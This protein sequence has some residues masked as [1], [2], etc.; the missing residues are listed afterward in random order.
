LSA[1]P[2]QVQRQADEAQRLED[3]LAAEKAARDNLN[4]DPKPTD[5]PEPEPKVEPKPTDAPAPKVE[6]PT[7]TPKPDENWEQ[8]F[9][10]LQGM[11]KA[12]L[13]REVNAALGDLQQKLIDATAKI[14]SLE[15]A[16]VKP[17]PTQTNPLVTDKDVEAFGGDLVD[18]IKRQAQEIVAAQGNQL[19]DKLAALE[20]ENAQLKKMVGGVTEKQGVSDRNS[21]NAQLKELVPDWETVNTL[22]NFL[23]WLA[24]IDSMTGFPRQAYLE[25][26]YGRFD[27]VRTASIFN[28]WKAQTGYG[29][30]PADPP[31]P[32]K[33]EPANDLE[34][35]VAPSTSQASTPVVENANQKVFTMKEIDQFYADCSKGVYKGKDDER[36]RIESE[37]DL[38]VAQGRIR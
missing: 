21:F 9:K 23:N 19:N 29:S 8:R 38:A 34:R 5:P 16:Q 37:I 6:E 36:Q 11:Y 10:T 18:L 31:A 2:E 35:H 33:Q 12:E 20:A 13:K 26:A 1:L 22:D 3:Q 24:E 7:P 14:E 15:K 25:D 27:A 30:K 28:T 17:E 4:Q 32:P